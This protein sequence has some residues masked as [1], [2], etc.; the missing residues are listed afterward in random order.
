MSAL[1]QIFIV[2]D[3]KAQQAYEDYEVERRKVVRKAK[4]FAKKHGA[5]PKR[6]YF[7][8]GAAFDFKPIGFV[9]P[10]GFK[11]DQKLWK[12][13]G[14]ACAEQTYLPKETSYARELFLE[15]KS[16]PKTN[17][18]NI[19]E[20]VGWKKDVF[21]HGMPGTVYFFAPFWRL[22]SKNKPGVYGFRSPMV[23]ENENKFIKGIREVTVTE[24]CKLMGE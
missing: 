11:F 5:D 2:E 4:A 20:A 17:T 3:V 15:Y 21:T 13:S 12:K 10:E 18:N 6:V 7:T 9:F 8:N 22:K 1:K 23:P 24:Y 14:Y 19:A 16:L